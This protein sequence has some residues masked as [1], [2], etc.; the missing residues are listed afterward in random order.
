M[1]YC[2]NCMSKLNNKGK[3][4]RCGSLEEAYVVQ[5][6]QLKPGYVLRDRYLI[7]NVIG[8]GGFGITYIG[9][10]TFFGKRVAIK[11]FYMTGFVNRY[12]SF[13]AKVSAETGEKGELFNR[14]REKFYEEARTMVRFCDIDG[15]VQ[16][17]DFFY[18]NETAYIVMEYIE[19]RTLQSILKEKKKLSV[20]ETLEIFKP[21]L[22]ALEVVHA[23]NVI[24]R[25]ISP[26]NIIITEDGKPW[27]IDFGAAREVA[28]DDMKS[29]S[30]ILKHGYAPEEQY[31][32]RG[33]QGPWTDIYAICATM[34]RCIGGKRP[35]DALERTVEDETEKLCK[36]APVCSKQLSDVIM[37]GLSVRQKERYQSIAEL[38]VDL[39]K[40][41]TESADVTEEPEPTT[42]VNIPVE[43]ENVTYEATEMVFPSAV[44]SAIQVEKP[45]EEIAYETAPAEEEAILEPEP[46][47]EPE[48]ETE[49]VDI[50]ENVEYE[51]TS[52][53][54]A[55]KRPVTVK[56]EPEPEVK[57]I[58]S[59]AFT[60]MEETGNDEK[61]YN[62]NNKEKVEQKRT[63]K[64]KKK[65]IWLIPVI[66]LGVGIL[67]TVCFV[68][69][70]TKPA[71]KTSASETTKPVT[72]PST[73]ETTKPATK[74]SAS[75]TTKPATKPST[76]ETT[77]PATSKDSDIKKA[78]VGDIVFFGSYEQDGITSNGTEPIEWEILS[79]ENGKALLI[80]KYVLDCQ[81]YNTED[82][83]DVTWE[84]CSL[85]KW[86]NSDFLNSA[87]DK[88][89]KSQIPEVELDNTDNPYYGTKGGNSTKDR[90][91]VLSVDEISKYYSFDTRNTKE[92]PGHS[93]EVIVK[94][95]SYAY[96]KGVYDAWI[97]ESDYNQYFKD[98]Y[99]SD[100][101]GSPCVS[102]WLRSPGKYGKYK[103]FVCDFGL[104]GWYGRD[105]EHGDVGVRPALYV[106][107]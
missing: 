17:K 39:E 102:W 93:D 71:T 37:K 68:F 43:Q 67:A 69:F 60:S 59:N 40:A 92:R 41:V 94:A 25:D 1:T 7:G 46:L 5:P 95:T 13:S 96:S 54:F 61:P 23:E 4:D 21:I 105:V 63:E 101:I 104:V 27:L 15:I 29:L 22:N 79:K 84:T 81:P 51:P 53:V 47:F 42:V 56:P 58:I 30:V 12:N 74:P 85:R 86:L 99:E 97:T 66:I 10:D 28:E 33:V 20:E 73:S 24:H 100:I 36:I 45:L 3:C 44:H 72:K 50:V 49:S 75:E 82:V 38:K 76:S 103:C 57:P 35:D 14:N 65:K 88:T 48:P 18:E 87:F 107:Y 90:I 55:T 78:S 16:V 80:S 91:F 2:Y 70:F 83:D 6:H 8:E 64:S 26:D 31:R 9:L 98:S 106:A 52:M 11:E 89:E 77:K 32:R 34:Y 19:G 62:H